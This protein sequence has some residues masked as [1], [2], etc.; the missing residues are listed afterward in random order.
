RISPSTARAVV[1][2]TPTAVGQTAAESIVAGNTNV[3]TSTAATTSVDRLF[4]RFQMTDKAEIIAQFARFFE[5]CFGGAIGVAIQ[6]GE[7]VVLVSGKPKDVVIAVAGYMQHAIRVCR[8]GPWQPTSF[9]LAQVRIPAHGEDH[10]TSRYI[11]SPP[12]THPKTKRLRALSNA[13]GVATVSL[14]ASKV[15]PFGVIVDPHPSA[16]SGLPRLC[17]PPDA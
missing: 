9:C 16:E 12:A 15:R 17:A 14:K 11:F 6:E 8:E 1:A 2:A 10:A 3:S 5:N 13:H 7:N 4:V